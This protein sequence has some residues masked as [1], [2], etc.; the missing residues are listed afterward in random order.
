MSAPMFLNYS[1]SPKES[2]WLLSAKDSYRS[3]WQSING[4]DSWAA[5]PW[6]W[7]IEFKRLEV[8]RG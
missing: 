1:T 5:N 3:L 6:V 2:D 7:R 8:P 4:A